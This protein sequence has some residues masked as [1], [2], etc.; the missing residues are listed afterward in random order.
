MLKVA[1][2]IMLSVLMAINGFAAADIPDADVKGAKDSPLVGRFA[3]S[4]IVSAVQKDF[5]ELALP[6][7]VLEPVKDKRDQ[8]NN[9]VY[10]PKQKKALEGKRTRLVYLTPAGASP[11]EVLRNYQ[12]DLTGKGATPLYEC[13]GEECGGSPTRSSGGGG[14]AMSLAMVLCPAENIK[15]PEL[16]TAHCAQSAGISDQRYLVMEMPD[17]GAYVSV[18]TY[19]MAAATGSCRTLKDRTIAVVDILEVKTMEAKM[20]T[21]KAEEMAEEISKKG[22]ISLYGIFFDSGKAEVKPESKDTL[23]QIAKLLDTTQDLR[24]LVVGHTDNVGDF[25]SNTELSKRRAAAVVNQLVSI[26]GIDK[27]RLTPVGVSY[28]CPVASN[29]TEEGRARNRRVELVEN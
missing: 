10:E 1:G 26:Y 12:Q 5:D 24:L 13:K 21:V 28:A 19:S 22:S 3:G 11:L 25:S 4:V 7:S 17:Q 15:E 29:A 2:I 23:D 16:T 9:I 8:H 20:V 27:S 18:L 6:L 14:G